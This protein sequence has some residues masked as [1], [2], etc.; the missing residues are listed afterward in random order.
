MRVEQG[1][2]L[3]QREL[4][5][6]LVPYIA[7]EYSTS[8]RDNQYWN[9]STTPKSGLRLRRVF[10]SK[11]IRWGE[12]TLGVERSQQRYH[13]ETAPENENKTELFVRVSMSGNWESN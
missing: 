10:T 6:R 3:G 4:A 12:A 8:N 9:N 2:E 11:T 5:W 1:L 7:V 13:S